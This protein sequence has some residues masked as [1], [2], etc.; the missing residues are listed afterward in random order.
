MRALVTGGGG[1]LGSAVVRRLLARGNDVTVLGRRRYAELEQLGVLCIQADVRD[2]GAIQQA[3]RGIDAVFHVAALAGVWG[4][5][6]DFWSINV[7]GTRNVVA[8][9]FDNGVRRLV[10]TSSPSVVFGR[11]SLCGVDESQPYPPKFAAEYPR[12]KAVAEQMVLAANGPAVATI[13]IR[14][15]LI[16]GPG[17]PYLIPRVVQRATSGKL[18]I[19]G[20]GR[21]RVDITYIDNAAEAH[22]LAADALGPS[23]ACAGR[24]YFVSQGEPVVLWDWINELLAGLGIPPATRK[25]PFRLAYAAGAALETI[26]HAGRRTSEPPMTRFVALQFAK[27]HYFNIAAAGRDFGF[28]PRISTQEGV[29]RVI[30]STAAMP[31]R[32]TELATAASSH[33]TGSC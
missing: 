6:R 17:D 10:Y 16:W 24:A 26:Y 27:D 33:S 20:D 18:K 8:A 19:V 31:G 23:A 28:Q 13:A 29:A 32:A 22:V 25:V 9:C 1:F 12:T 14:P 3:C 15:H 5:P 4:D 11:T 7:E 30:A 21:N 2:A